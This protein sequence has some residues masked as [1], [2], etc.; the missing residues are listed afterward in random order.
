MFNVN[1]KI[2]FL[3]NKFLLFSTLLDLFCVYSLSK[4]FI[5]AFA[6]GSRRP[7]PSPPELIEQPGSTTENRG[8]TVKLY[9]E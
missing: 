1:L 5:L 7:K 2:F 9:C 3:N 8:A 4:I 6:A